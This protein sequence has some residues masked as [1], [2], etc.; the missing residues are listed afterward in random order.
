MDFSSLKELGI[1]IG[2]LC[3][4]AL[5]VKY[6]LQAMKDSREDFCKLMSNHIEHNTAA[7]D[8][9]GEVINRNTEVLSKLSKKM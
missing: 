7:I 5:I 8:K 2:A 3:I 6:F 1:G 9:L 4:V